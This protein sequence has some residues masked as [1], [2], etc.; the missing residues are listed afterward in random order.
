MKNITAL[1]LGLALSAPAFAQDGPPPPPAEVHENIY[2]FKSKNG[3][4]VLPQKCDWAI[5]ISATSFFG[6]FGNWFNNSTVVL[7]PTYN[8]AG[9]PT[10]FAIG[11]PNLGGGALLVKYMAKSDLAYRARFQINAGT[12]DYRNLVAKDVPTPDP[13]NP[14]YVTDIQSNRTYVGLLGLG[15]EKR[16]GSSR[17]Q[18]YFGAE[19][20]LGFSG[21]NTK[22]TYGNGFSTDFPFPIS[23]TD[24]LS[25]SSGPVIARVKEAKTGTTFLCGARG[26]IGAEF[27][28]APKMSIGG[29]IGYTLGFSTHGEGSTTTQSWDAVASSVRNVE[30]K[31]FEN[32]GLRSWGIGMDNVNASINFN[33]YF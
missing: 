13:F 17:L 29:E 6:Y 2:S 3:H 9:T 22:Y 20:L 21:A 24:F 26:F 4:E 31:D 32:N 11:N 7:A 25:G 8:T 1:C 27:F 12:V 28:F 18:G 19:L 15:F 5:G 16:R 30:T 14:Q 10:A 33:F 23:T